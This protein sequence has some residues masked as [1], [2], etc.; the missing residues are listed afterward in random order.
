[1]IDTTIE[2]LYDFH[3]DTNNLPRITPPWID[4]TI[5]SLDLPLHVKSHIVLAI[6][7]FGLTQRWKMEIAAMD[8]PSLV[9]DKAIE[10]PFK[11]FIHEHRFRKIDENTTLME[12]VVTFDLL[13]HPLSLLALPLIKRDLEKMFS[14]RHDQTKK[15]LERETL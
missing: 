4:V 1:M 6:K 10:S 7:R 8:R 15:I 9:C 11:T 2:A 3:C 14:Y 5:V 13:L 12:D